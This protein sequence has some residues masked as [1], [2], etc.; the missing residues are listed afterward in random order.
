VSGN[1]TLPTIVR[2]LGT[3]DSPDS[4]C[5]HCGCTG[6]YIHRFVVDDGRTLAAMSG[7][8]KLF[9]VSRIALEEQR[10]MKKKADYEKKGWHLNRDDSAALEA[11]ARFF[12]GE[13]DERTAL[14]R[15]DSAKANNGNRARIRR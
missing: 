14:S 8:V 7:C 5:P 10:L 13:F 6:R 1:L 15:V 12:A 3:D 2:F 4:S 9:P 11:I